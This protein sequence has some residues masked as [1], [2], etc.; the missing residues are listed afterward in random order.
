MHAEFLVSYRPPYRV[1]EEYGYDV[2]PVCQQ[3]TNMHGSG[4]VHTCYFYKRCSQ[5]RQSVTLLS[6]CSKVTLPPRPGTNDSPVTVVTSDL[7]KEAVMQATGVSK[8][9]TLSV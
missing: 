5:P 2:E 7:F 8:C 1:M 4:E 6:G 9:S 3:P